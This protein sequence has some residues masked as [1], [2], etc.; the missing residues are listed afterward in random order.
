M[1]H[2][3]NYSSIDKENIL[4]CLEF[5][6]THNLFSF[7]G[8]FYLQMCWAGMGGSIFPVF[9]Q[10]LH[11]LVGAGRI[12]GDGNPFHSIVKFY[13]RYIDDLLLVCS[14]AVGDLDNFLDYLND[15]YLNLQFTRQMNGELINF[16]NVTFFSE[17]GHI[18]SS[19][20][21]KPNSGNTFLFADSGHPH[22]VTCGIHVCQFLRLR[23]VCSKE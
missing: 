22:H 23:R 20:Y 1:D 9:C 8:G 21:R 17:D 18:Q 4:E 3:S 5:L 14:D 13:C 2:A 11:G 15:K 6:L 10:P 7:G 12:F 19:I 16:L